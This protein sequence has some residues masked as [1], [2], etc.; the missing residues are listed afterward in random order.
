MVATRS[1]V[2]NHRHGCIIVKDGEV[3]AEGFNY[4][5][6]HFEHKFS[7]HAE[8]DALMKLKKLKR[9]LPECELYVVR[10]GTDLMGNP[11]KYSRPCPDCTRAILNAGIK[12]VY[13]ST[14]EEFMKEF[15]H[16]N[17]RYPFMDS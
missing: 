15:H 11:L 14:S 13:F 16:P 4:Y 12:R 7:I 6:N 3:L 1:N 2:R 10:I 8:V 9:V 5:T 17:N